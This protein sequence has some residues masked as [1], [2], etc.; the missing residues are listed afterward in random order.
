[1]F[2]LKTILPLSA[3][4]VNKVKLS[5]KEGAVYQR[6]LGLAQKAC[7]R[8]LLSKDID[9]AYFNAVYLEDRCFQIKVKPKIGLKFNLNIYLFQF[10]SCWSDNNVANRAEVNIKN[11]DEEEE[12]LRV[13]V[14]AI[15]AKTTS[16]RA[17]FMA[18]EVVGNMLADMA[19]KKMIIKYKKSFQLEDLAGVDFYFSVLDFLGFVVEIP[20]QVKSSV[21]GQ[22]RHEKKHADIPSLVVRPETSEEELQEKIMKIAGAY[23]AKFK[24]V[25]HV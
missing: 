6:I 4:G 11:D 18:E 8:A 1:M 19:G 23:S 17:G 13:L 9:G 16:F 14:E 12:I 3:P 15:R 2:K 24:K 22:A 25:L 20:L 5:A 21:G 10:F 7:M